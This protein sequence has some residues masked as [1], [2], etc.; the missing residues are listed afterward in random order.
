MPDNRNVTIVSANGGSPDSKALSSLAKGLALGLGFHAAGIASREKLLDFCEIA[1]FQ[2][3]KKR[4]DLET[5]LP[6]ARSAICV[7]ASYFAGLPS[8]ESAF[9]AKF[10][11]ASDYHSAL[12]DRLAVLAD[13]IAKAIGPFRWRVCVDTGPISDRAAA[14][15]AGLGSFGKNNCLYIPNY[16]SWV[17]LGELVTDLDLIPD[18]PKNDDIC[19][20]CAICI[21]NCPT[22]A[23]GESHAFDREKCLSDATQRRTALPNE[24]ASK[25]GGRIYGCDT[26][27]DVCPL[28]KDAKKT[29]WPEF[30]RPN[31]AAENAGMDLF[32]SMD[33]KDFERLFNGT[34]MRWC[35]RKTIARNALIAKGVL[36]GSQRSGL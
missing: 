13:S 35:G 7:A 36:G 1:G 15:C 26:C 31:L 12:A 3:F 20:N 27:Q 32:A 2:K 22:A 19:G 23:L 24:I 9:I 14:Y 28:N 6:G 17:V 29:D 21:E 5:A 11:R 4:F 18:T 8:N 33:E 30:Q 16:G 10:A 34:A 25:L